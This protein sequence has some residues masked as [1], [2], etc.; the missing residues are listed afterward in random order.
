MDVVDMNY[1][2]LLETGDNAETLDFE[3]FNLQGEREIYKI[4]LQMSTLECSQDVLV[5]TS[6][7]FEEYVKTIF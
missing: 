1:T 4:I 5:L 2:L 6:K 7:W 3:F